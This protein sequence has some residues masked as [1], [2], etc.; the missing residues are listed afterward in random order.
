M[1]F[2]LFF[3]INFSGVWHKNQKEEKKMK[4]KS[5]FISKKHIVIIICFKKINNN[6]VGFIGINPE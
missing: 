3:Y 4:R 5:K 1:C 6:G 2:I